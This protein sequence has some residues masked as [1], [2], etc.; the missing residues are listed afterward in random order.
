[1]NNYFTGLFHDLPEVL[2]RDIINPVKES[3]KGLD[4]LI[5]GY[6]KEEMERKIYGLLPEAW[7][8]EI[9]LYTEDEFSDLPD[10]NGSLVK[11][12]DDLAAFI[13]AYL[14]IKNGIQNQDF[15]DAISHIRSK[16]KGR[17]VYGINLDEIYKQFQI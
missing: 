1:M 8:Q 17:K 2:T 14:S 10:R 12:A 15:R 3:V 4:Q 16:Y 5:K 7:H 11:T 13:E 9:K 6:E